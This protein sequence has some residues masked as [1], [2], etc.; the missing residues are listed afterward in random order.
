M[1]AEVCILYLVRFP[2]Y[3]TR[4]QYNFFEVVVPKIVKKTMQIFR[5]NC[6]KIGKFRLSLVL[7]WSWRQFS[8]KDFICF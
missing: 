2:G 7:S 4:Q 3:K 1:E 5:K 6:E 8:K